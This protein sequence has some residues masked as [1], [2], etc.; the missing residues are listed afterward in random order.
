M[1]GHTFTF[2]SLLGSQLPI[3][4]TCYVW[5]ADGASTPYVGTGFVAVVRTPS[6]WMPQTETIARGQSFWLYPL[7]GTGPTN[8]SFYGELP[9]TLYAETSSIPIININTNNFHYFGNPYPLDVTLTNLQIWIN[10]VRN[11]TFHYWDAT[12]GQWRLWSKGVSMSSPSN[13]IL[14]RGSGFV[15]R[16]VNTA[17]YDRLWLE[18]KSYSWP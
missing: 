12:N 18:P 17:T 14:R 7:P 10:A 16:P 1:N 6:G 9:A 13:F 3:G 15:F 5:R 2:D 8:I 11:D 4:T